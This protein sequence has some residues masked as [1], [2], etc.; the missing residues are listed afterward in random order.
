[1]IMKYY[2][3]DKGKGPYCEGPEDDFSWINYGS[4]SIEVPRRPS[5][6]HIW[7]GSA[8]ERTSESLKSIYEPKRISELRRVLVYQY[9]TSLSNNQ[10][11]ERDMYYSKL[12]ELNYND[13]N[14]FEFPTCPDFMRN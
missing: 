4:N 7:N 11:A 2:I 12:M 13:I 3:R 6:S 8:W 5:N 14:N 10:K 1:M 9:D